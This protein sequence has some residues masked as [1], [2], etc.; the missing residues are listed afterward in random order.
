MGEEAK[1]Q[2]FN[3]YSKYFIAAVVNGLLIIFLMREKPKRL[4]SAG[5]EQ[6]K[7]TLTKTW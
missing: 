7:T 2:I 5:A 3:L 4:P 1:N 6:E